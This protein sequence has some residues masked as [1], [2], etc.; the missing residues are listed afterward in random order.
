MRPWVARFS[1]MV[2][3]KSETG[4]QGPLFTKLDI[5]SQLGVAIGY[6]VARVAQPE[7]DDVLKHGGIAPMGGPEA[8]EGMETGDTVFLHPSRCRA[9]MHRAT[10]SALKEEGT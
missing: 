10:R 7:A 6:V 1:Q 9:Q 5:L 3:G 2:Q 8:S 4:A